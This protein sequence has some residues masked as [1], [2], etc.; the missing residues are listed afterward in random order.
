MGNSFNGSAV[1]DNGY[2]QA[3]E[4]IFVETLIPFHFDLPSGNEALVHY[5]MQEIEFSDK[6][7]SW[8][9]TPSDRKPFLITPGAEQ[10][11]GIGLAYECLTRLHGLAKLHN[12][13]DYMQKF[14]ILESDITVWFIEDGDGGAITALLPSEY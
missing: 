14:E 6:R 12:G 11:I 2:P 1:P 9:F 5:R 7:S 8:R 3:A 13:I 10:A 4:T